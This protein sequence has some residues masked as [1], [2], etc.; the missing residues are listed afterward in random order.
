MQP[1]KTDCIYEINIKKTT[2]LNAD[3]ADQ[4]IHQERKINTK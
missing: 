1:S 4:V 3:V 2:L